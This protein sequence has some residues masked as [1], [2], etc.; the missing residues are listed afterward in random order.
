MTQRGLRDAVRLKVRQV[1][2]G[3]R[4]AIASS[5]RVYLT[6]ARLK[7]P[8]QG[9]EPEVVRGHTQLVIEGFPRSANTFA[10][11]AFQLAQESAVRTAHHL[12]AS[13]QLIAGARM[14]VPT[15]A[16][17]RE[18]EETIIS[19][20]LRKPGISVRQAMRSYIR[21][22]EPLEPYRERFTVGRFDQVI[23]D[24]GSVI[25]KL[26]QRFGTSFRPFEHTEE[27]VKEC[28]DLI[29]ERT[30]RSSVAK[31]IGYLESGL[32][33]AEE[34]RRATRDYR[35]PG[36][37][38]AASEREALYVARPSRERDQR[39][40]AIRGPFWHPDLTG[41]RDEAF[42]LYERFAFG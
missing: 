27:K 20:V 15:M 24:F 42:A 11:V 30:R 31:Y 14:R 6:A 38:H 16:L 34:F 21:F 29:E 7:Y 18:P 36:S 28:F 39:K 23:G 40:E 22:Y 2:Y 3:A 10:V 41:L 35:R 26:N 17:I 13:S 4:S 32:I 25:E 9:R 19:E 33:S 1:G 8:H 5:P 37:G 12:H